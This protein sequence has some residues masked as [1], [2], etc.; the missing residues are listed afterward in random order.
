MTAVNR[1]DGLSISTEYFEMSLVHGFH[2]CPSIWFCTNWMHFPCLTESDCNQHF[3]ISTKFCGLNQQSTWQQQ[4]QG[5][6]SLSLIKHRAM[7]TYG[8]AEVLLHAFWNSAPNG[9]D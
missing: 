7:I 2:L 8:R 4:W 1:A 5:K 6:L 3:N 9:N